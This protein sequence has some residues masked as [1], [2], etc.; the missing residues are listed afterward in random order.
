MYGQPTNQKLLI[1][2]SAG[3]SNSLQTVKKVHTRDVRIANQSQTLN[4]KI[5]W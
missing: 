5:T 4:S 2:R 1:V 3:V